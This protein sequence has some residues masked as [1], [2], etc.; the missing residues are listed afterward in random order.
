MLTDAQLAGTDDSHIEFRDGV[1]LSSACWM[2]LAALQQDAQQA[3]FNLQVASAYR[4]YARQR[5]IFNAKAL[6]ERAVHDDAGRLLDIAG[7]DTVTA[8][9]AILR[10]S[11]LPGTSRHHWGTD[12]DIY[13]AAAVPSGYD[14]QLTPEEVADTG[15]FGPLHRWLD[16]QIQRGAAHGFFR[17]YDVDRGGVA[18]ERWH[19]S[20]APESSFCQQQLDARLL[21]RLLSQADALQPAVM[22][23]TVL[24]HL[25]ALL[26]QYV[27]AVAPVP[28][29][30]G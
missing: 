18:P 21:E 15:V 5:T 10:F 27:S 1:G 14:V 2:A 20:Y 23:Q 16:V 9:H 4:S 28:N 30:D 3:G 29:V 6:G 24:E 11:A 17:P 8:L 19:L 22:A 7:M 26:E 12:L 13:D 25:P